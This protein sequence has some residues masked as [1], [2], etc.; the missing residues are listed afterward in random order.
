MSGPSL[1][2]AIVYVV[3]DDPE[4][5]EG[6]AWLLDSCQLRF[7]LFE[8]ADAFERFIH[9]DPHCLA[10]KREWPPHPCCLLLDVCM[11]GTN[12]HTLFDRLVAEGLT[13]RLPV[14]FLTG[15]G[16]LAKAVTALQRGAFDFI[17]KPCVG[18]RLVDRTVDALMKSAAA[19]G[20]DERFL[21]V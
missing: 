19:L 2:S 18:N 9:P 1:E 17:E 3:D 4:M 16:H 6:L 15:H 21:A 20:G 13:A 8:S 10:A 5:R 14:I 12:G 11:P 7:Q